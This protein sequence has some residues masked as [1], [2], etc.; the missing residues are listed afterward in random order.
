VYSTW[1]FENIAN[2]KGHN[3]KV[4]SIYFVK[5]DSRLIS[6]G[7]DG[8]I[9]DWS[10]KDLKREG[11]NVIKSCSYTCA[12]S[13]VDGRS[14]YAVGSDKIIKEIRDSQVVKEIDS[15]VILTQITF[16]H[17]GRM[18]FA[19]T[20]TGTVRALKFPFSEES[21]RSEYQEH[22]AHAAA[23]TKIRVSYDDQ[24]LFSVSEDGTLFKFKISD[25]EGRSNK[26]ENEIIYAEEVKENIQSNVDSCY[27]VRFRRKE[28]CDG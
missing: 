4:R 7:M 8:A 12:I 13:S 18:L 23:I 21:S 26:K 17:S 22:Q 14:L 2:L 1:T 20:A 5:D 3:G 9:Y 28:Y 19:G 10:L 6:A 16:S 11:E 27:K 25:K 15:D 24:Y